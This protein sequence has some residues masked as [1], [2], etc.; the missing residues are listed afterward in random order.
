MKKIIIGLLLLLTACSSTSNSLSDDD[1][2][3]LNE[4]LQ[5]LKN[6]S[7]IS[8]T[9]ELREDQ[10]FSH[11]EERLTETTTS[12][13]SY[14]LNED[15]DNIE[16]VHEASIARQRDFDA[17]GGSFFI[18]L[19]DNVVKKHFYDE[20]KEGELEE[21]ATVDDLKDYSIYFL[22]TE[23]FSDYDK[24]TISKKS[25]QSIYSYTGRKTNFI[26]FNELFSLDEKTELIEYSL[27]I[28]EGSLKEITLITVLEHEGGT[29]TKNIKL[30]I[31]ALNDDVDVQYVVKF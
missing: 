25:K 31:K 28:E 26:D 17:S 14:R 13:I 2:T 27:I 21:G 22:E 29:S 1:I 23:D 19:K 7:A 5:D 3:Q 18:M 24:M 16:Y 20:G 10:T 9:L 12:Y 4:A 30:S 6:S 11:N 15:L 8:M